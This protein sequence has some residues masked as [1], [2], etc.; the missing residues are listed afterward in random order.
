MPVTG[1]RRVAVE[2]GLSNGDT[3]VN[4]MHIKDNNLGVFDLTEADLIEADL[5]T[6]FDDFKVRIADNVVMERITVSDASGPG[7]TGLS[8]EYALSVAGTAVSDP[9]PYSTALVVSLKTA[10][11]S[12]RGRGR[13]Y[14]CGFAENSNTNNG[15][16][17]S[18]MRAD[19]LSA[20]VDLNTALLVHDHALGV[21]SRTGDVF[22]PVVTMQCDGHWDTQRR[23][24]NRR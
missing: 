23:R 1:L 19:V 7:G 8:F 22:N 21:Y 18:V 13:V 12:R 4:V 14:L 11:N 3:A 17:D 6:W 2:F 9:L 5:L 16:P 20:F 10:L 24:A 15:E